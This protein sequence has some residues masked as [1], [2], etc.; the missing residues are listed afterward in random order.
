MLVHDLSY[1]EEVSEASIIEGGYGYWGYDDQLQKVK[2]YQDATALAGN[3][4]GNFGN[5]AIAY[6]I[7]NV[8]QVD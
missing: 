8:F 1:M 6:N 2:I 3:G 7:A 4:T 5:T